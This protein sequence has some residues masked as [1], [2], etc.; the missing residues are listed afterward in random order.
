MT[1]F[2]ICLLY[3]SRGIHRQHAEGN[4]GISRELASNRPRQALDKPRAD[5]GQTA[6]RDGERAAVNINKYIEKIKEGPVSRRVS[7]I[8]IV[9]LLSLTID[10]DA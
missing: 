8:C 1:L 7:R 5:C 6:G 9:A 3:T 2:Y 10:N 4:D